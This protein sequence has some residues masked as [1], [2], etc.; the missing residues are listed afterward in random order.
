MDRQPE[1]ARRIEQA[2]REKLGHA[3]EAPDDDLM[4]EEL[5]NSPGSSDGRL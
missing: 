2:A 5:S 1:I 3:L 4:S